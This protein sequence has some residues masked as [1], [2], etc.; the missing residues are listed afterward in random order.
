L[1]SRG[2]DDPLSTLLSIG[3]LVT[4]AV[5]CWI[6]VKMERVLNAD[7][8]SLFFPWKVRNPRQHARRIDGVLATSIRRLKSGEDEEEV[9]ATL[10]LQVD[11]QLR[12][13]AKRHYARAVEH[14]EEASRRDWVFDAERR[15]SALEEAE[16]ALWMARAEYLRE[17]MR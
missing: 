13:Q 16:R 17:M 7:G 12:W 2:P 1:Q 11:G 15:E 3:A 4:F 8:E 14:L 10:H 6:I 9:L 5:F